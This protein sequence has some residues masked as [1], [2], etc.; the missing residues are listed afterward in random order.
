MAHQSPSVSIEERRKFPRRELPP[1]FDVSLLRPQ[2]AVPAQSINVSEG[3]LCV[4]L[5]EMVEVRSLVRLQVTPVEGSGS[6]RGQRPMECAGRVA[7]V[8]QRLDLRSAPPFLFDVGV[9][10]V[11]PPPLLRPPRSPI[12][13][14][15]R[16]RLESPAALAPG[17]VGGRGAMLQRPVSR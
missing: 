4:R 6:G 10:F 9:E 17:R 1:R 7:W 14:A 13:P 15:A 8:I 2:G 11:D 3:G 16:A 12:H 5:E